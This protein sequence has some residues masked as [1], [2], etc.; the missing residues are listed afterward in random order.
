MLAVSRSATEQV[1]SVVAAA[2]MFVAVVAVVATPLVDTGN[3]AKS[4]NW[5]VV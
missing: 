5:E 3:M 1:V 2:V 4:V